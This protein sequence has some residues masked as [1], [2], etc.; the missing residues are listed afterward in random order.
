MYIYIYIN[1]VDQKAKK[2]FPIR[3]LTAPEA[4]VYRG[5][6]LIRYTLLPRTTIGP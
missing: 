2:E 4:R 5:T 3:R 1:L 6:S